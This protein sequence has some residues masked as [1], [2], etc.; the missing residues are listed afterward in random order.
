MP[1]VVQ[2]RSMDTAAFVKQIHKLP[3]YRGQVVH[4]ERL[5]ARRARYGS[6]DRPLPP[7]LQSDL[8][9]IGASKLFSHQAQ[10]INAVRAGKHVILSTGTASGKTLAYN[11]P[12]LE[13][14][15]ANSRARALYLFPTKALAHD[16]LRGLRELAQH[17]PDSSRFGTYDGDT[18]RGVRGRL[19]REASILLTNPDMLHLG[20]LPNHTLWA[21][22]FANLR[23]V[24][25]D[26]AHVYRGVFGSP[27]DAFGWDES[28]PSP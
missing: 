14:L 8:R 16:Q 21:D 9:A 17:G 22:F 4:V 28:P 5:K 11:I 2:C 25:L 13:A 3:G 15:L 23:F 1:F 27:V 12:V 18:P 19:R 6:L 26:E 10:A 20:I 7:A 24:V